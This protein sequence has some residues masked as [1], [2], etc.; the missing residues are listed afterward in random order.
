MNRHTAETDLALYASGDLPVWRRLAASWHVR[1]CEECRGLVE[2]FRSDREGLHQAA[3]RLPE[4]ILPID[5]DQLSAE[6]TANIHVGLAAGE[7]VTPRVPKV[8][9]LAWWRPAAAA[10]G[11]LVL[12]AGAWW[13][14]V[15]RSDTETIG[16]ALHDMVTVQRGTVAQT[17]V[18]EDR[19]PMVGASSAGIEL[20]ENGGRMK[21][22]QSGLQPVMYSVSTQGSA[23]TR[24]VDEETA[25]VT[26][27]A[28]YV[29]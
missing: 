9:A 22:E 8:E 15:P 17:T 11:V 13:L 16:R 7:C 18:Q 25:Q 2:T 3:D 23:S 29:Q 12:V 14:N 26:I 5:W 4:D 10:A 20:V 19:G 21:I 1:G 24:W 28:V 6:M 27:T